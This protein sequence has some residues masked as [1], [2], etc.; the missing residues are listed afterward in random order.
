MR[1]LVRESGVQSGVQSCKPG[2]NGP[3]RD[4]MAPI[5]Q[6]GLCGLN[7]C[8]KIPAVWFDPLF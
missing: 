3:V 2:C 1:V 5:V 6:G 8:S 7:L 4:I